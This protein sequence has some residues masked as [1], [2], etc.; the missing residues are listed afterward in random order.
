VV[1]WKPVWPCIPSAGW[2]RVD[3]EAITDAG[4]GEQSSPALL[5]RRASV[6]SACEY[7]A[8]PDERE[9]AGIAPASAYKAR[10]PVW[11]YRQGWRPGVALFA[12]ERAVSVRYRQNVGL[13][14]SVDTVLPIDLA[15]GWSRTH[16]WTAASIAGRQWRSRWPMASETAAAT[17]PARRGTWKSRAGLRRSCGEDEIARHRTVRGRQWN[18]R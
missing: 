2:Q 8:L 10:Q 7:L 12:S 13:G 6:I 3:V 16:T 18:G 11:V 14:T 1:D 4:G 17:P 9:R 15:L 5:P